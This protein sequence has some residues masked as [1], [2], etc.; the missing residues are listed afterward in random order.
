MYAVIETGGKQYKVQEGDKL[1]VEKL[2]AQVG[3]TV[4]FDKVLFLGGDDVKVG[5]P[6]VE[7]A[8]VEAKVLEQN[9]AKKVVVYKFKAKK[10]YRNKRG[11][12]QPY[13]FIEIGTIA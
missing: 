4:T 8:K 2:D 3:D 10:N 1:R 7:G 9:K 5:R 11:H 12:R 13:T 6:Y